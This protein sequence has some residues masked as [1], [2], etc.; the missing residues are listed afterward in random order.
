MHP[1]LIM[2]D[3]SLSNSKILRH[4]VFNSCQG[5]DSYTQEFLNHR[6]VTPANTGTSSRGCATC[7]GVSLTHN[8]MKK[9]KKR[10]F[11]KKFH[12]TPFKFFVFLIQI[13]FL[14]NVIC[15]KS[16]KDIIHTIFMY[17]YYIKIL[18]KICFFKSKLQS[19]NQIFAT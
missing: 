5:W 7:D 18:F 17:V 13:V 10:F 3:N 14:S 9:K 11:L 16:Y 15:S 12:V 1:N 8:Q 4:G 6:S 2:L 19:Y